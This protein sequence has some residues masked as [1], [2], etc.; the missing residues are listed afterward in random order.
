MPEGADLNVLRKMTL[1][2]DLTSQELAELGALLRR[3]T[4]LAGSNVMTA[5]QPGEIVYIIQEGTVK[6]HLEQSSG[7]DVILA[8]LGVGEVVGEMS[9]VDRLS[10]SATVLSLEDTSLLWMNRA[11]FRQYLHRI[12]QLSYNL[13]LILSHRLRLANIRIQSLSTLDVYGRIARQILAFAEEYADT[14][15]GAPAYIPVRLTQSDLA[16]LVGA[17]RVRVNQVLVD[18][19]ER[20][21]ISVSPNHHITVL[22]QK[23]L[24]DRCQ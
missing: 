11:T 1:F 8:I 23:A 2:Q 10:R 7:R 6:I 17:S 22:D 12:P 14:E 16:D 18:Y 20:G 15:A 13:A 3:R 4:V 24:L 5:E 21:Y 19:K 9:L